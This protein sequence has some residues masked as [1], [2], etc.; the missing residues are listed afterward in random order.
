VRIVNE[1]FCHCLVSSHL[2][3]TIGRML[4]KCGP[5]DGWQQ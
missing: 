4:R 2:E 1:T 3:E 5:S